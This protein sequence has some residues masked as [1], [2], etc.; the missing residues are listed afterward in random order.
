MLCWMSYSTK[1]ERNAIRKSDFKG[2]RG[3]PMMARVWAKVE[4]ARNGQCWRWLASSETTGHANFNIGGTCVPAYKLL[5]EHIF[6]TVPIGSI[7]HHKCHNSRC[8]NPFHL[9]LLTN[10]SAHCAMHS[11]T[12]CIR[13]HPMRDPNLYYWHGERHCRLCRI[14]SPINRQIVLDGLS[15]K[16]LANATRHATCK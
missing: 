6:G 11:K 3:I 13:G 10:Q 12:H 9:Q 5:Y 2:E 16:E 8:V 4:I 15:T 7:L 1:S 14:R